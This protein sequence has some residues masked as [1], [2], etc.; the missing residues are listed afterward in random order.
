MVLDSILP[1]CLVNIYTEYLMREA[2]V[3]GEGININGQNITNIRY[4]DDAIIMAES[5]NI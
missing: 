2:L 3:D 1:P 5:F 4:A